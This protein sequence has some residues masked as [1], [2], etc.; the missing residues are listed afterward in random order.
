[1]LLW[2]I[3]NARCVF[4]IVALGLSFI[5]FKTRLSPVDILSALESGIR[6]TVAVSIACACAGLIIGSVFVSGLGLKFTQSV[7]EISGGNLLILLSL[8]GVAIILGM[9]I[10]T[11]AVYITVAALIVPAVIKAGVE[12][13]AAHMFAFVWRGFDHYTAR[14]SGIFCRGGYCQDPTYGN[15]GRVNKGWHC[16]ISGSLDFCL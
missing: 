4:G 9:G 2:A 5:H 16:K 13:I 11:T 6:A 7:I 12:P 10:T 3:A 15:S 1:M 8:T 14:C